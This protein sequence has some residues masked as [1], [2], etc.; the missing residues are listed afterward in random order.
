MGNS[1]SVLINNYNYGRFLAEAIQ[2]ALDQSVRPSEVLV[3]DDGSTDD[4]LQ[5][6]AQAFSRNPAVRV[7]PQRNGGQLSAFVSGFDQAA[8]DFIFLLDA[9]DRYL[10]DHLAQLLQVYERHRDVDFAFTGH[11]K[12][13]AATAVHQ[14]APH[15]RH[16]GL[17]AARTLLCGAWIGSVTSTLSLRRPLAQTLLPVLR[18][19]SPRWRI[20]ADDC[21]VLGASLAGARKFFSAAPSVEYRIH[22]AN[23]FFG[24]SGAT[25]AD[26]YAHWL[27]RDSLIA[28]FARELGVRPGIA[29]RAEVEF[30][31]VQQPTRAEYEDYVALVRRSGLPWGARLKQR[32]HLY[33]HFRHR[34]APTPAAILPVD[35][36]APVR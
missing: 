36:P 21:L 4:S 23:H 20:R 17:S 28:V 12:F 6:V 15:D 8:G 35:S 11:R 7:V 1:V 33:R 9:D 25:E 3:I 26:D 22:A 31:T 13:G 18:L 34:A 27:R 14:L 30:R 29:A 24:R 32:A 10:P 19:L 2:S 5:M 16:L